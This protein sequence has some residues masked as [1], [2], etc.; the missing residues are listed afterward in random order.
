MHDV[1][2]DA[3][4]CDSLEVDLHTLALLEPSKIL[5]STEAVLAKPGV[6]QEQWVVSTEAV[7]V[8]PGA[9]Q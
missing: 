2:L 4:G 7:L 3:R 8:S 1:G 9:A 5:K 6:A